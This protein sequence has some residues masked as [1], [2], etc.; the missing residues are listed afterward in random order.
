MSEREGEKERVRERKRKRKRKS[1]RETDRQ[2]DRWKERE[3][4]GYTHLQVV[5]TKLPAIFHYQFH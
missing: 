5:W 4:R 2:T 3:E 1:E